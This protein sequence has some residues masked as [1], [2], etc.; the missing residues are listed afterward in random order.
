MQPESFSEYDCF[1]LS[2]QIP[3]EAIPVGTIG[4]VLMVLDS[5]QRV[6]EVEFPDDH[7][8]NPGSKPTFTLG[9]D[10]MT[11]DDSAG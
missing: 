3:S 7:G 2:K 10:F 4:V 8:R 1:R 6:Y 9:G 5:A 11:P